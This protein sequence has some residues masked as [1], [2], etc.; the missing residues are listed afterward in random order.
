MYEST[1]DVLYHLYDKL[2]IGYWLLVGTLSWMTGLGFLQKTLV[3]T[4]LES[5]EFNLKLY[6]LMVSVCIGKSRRM[7]T[8]STGDMSS[9]SS[10]QTRAP[11]R[12][13]HFTRFGKESAKR[14][15]MGIA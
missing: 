5:M 12:R 1:V 7:L 11:T 8:F 15:D 13:M 4:F 3:K 10:K 6:T 14:H 9:P 2:S